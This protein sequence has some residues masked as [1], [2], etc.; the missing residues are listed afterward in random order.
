MKEIL[1][2]DDQPSRAI[3]LLPNLG[4]LTFAHGFDQIN[5][6]L[7][8]SPIKWD[9]ILL[10]MDMPLMDG[11]DVSKAFLRECKLPVIIISLN[12]Y[13]SEWVYG[14]LLD[15]G[16]EAYYIQVTEKQDGAML[17]NKKIIHLLERD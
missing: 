13:S 2:V 15:W 10:D 8:Y 1:W 16:V 11:R 5:Y 7:N 3:A 17:L 12:P 4:R 6:Y 14:D 9:L